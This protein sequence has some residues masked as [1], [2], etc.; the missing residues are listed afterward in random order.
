MGT[1][2]DKPLMEKNAEDG[3]NEMCMWGLCSMQGW[4]IAQED[5]HIACSINQSDGSQG[6][7]FCVFDGHGGIDVSRHVEREFKKTFIG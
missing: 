4:R 7:L 1:F 2:L 6:M 5:A 3:E